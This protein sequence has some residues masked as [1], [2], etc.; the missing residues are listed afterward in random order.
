[1]HVCIQKKI[2]PGW[3]HMWYAYCS[4][5]YL[6]H[7]IA[8]HFMHSIKYTSYITTILHTHTHAHSA[9]HALIS[10]LCMYYTYFCRMNPSAH[11]I[12]HEAPV[13]NPSSMSFCVTPCFHKPSKSYSSRPCPVIRCTMVS[14]RSITSQ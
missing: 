9:E 5:A 8:S 3:Y 1:M 6:L 11:F 12:T 13:Q 10:Y 2:C 4:N 14:R 7:N